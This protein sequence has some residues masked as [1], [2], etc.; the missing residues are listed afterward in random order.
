[1]NFY[2]IVL[3]CLLSCPLSLAHT[4]IYHSLCIFLSFC[5][6]VFYRTWPK[7]CRH[8]VHSLEWI[9]HYS[10]M[11]VMRTCPHTF[12]HEVHPVCLLLLHLPLRLSLLS[13]LASALQCLL[14]PSGVT[15]CWRPGEEVRLPVE[16]VSSSHDTTVTSDL[17]LHSELGHLIWPRISSCP[18]LA[19][20]NR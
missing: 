13:L 15:A 16:E 2:I 7:V 18:P 14:I 17:L 5:I 8:T 10:H 1:M 6:N 19:P 4:L 3:F 9:V 12:G 20:K 11:A